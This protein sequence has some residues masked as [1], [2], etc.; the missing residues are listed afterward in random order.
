MMDAGLVWLSVDR[1]SSNPDSRASSIA[2]A[3]PN[4]YTTATARASSFCAAA[5]ICATTSSWSDVVDAMSAS[6]DVLTCS[7]ASSIDAI[8]AAIRIPIRSKADAETGNAP[9][10][11]RLT[12]FSGSAALRVFVSDKASSSSRLRPAIEPIAWPW[13][14]SAFSKRM[15]CTSSS[16]YRRCPDGVLGGAT[17]P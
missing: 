17:T 14:T 5:A 2:S 7:L 1:N 6:A 12:S 4:A 10:T 15:R 11:A 3:V 16:E 9:M 8:R 13:L